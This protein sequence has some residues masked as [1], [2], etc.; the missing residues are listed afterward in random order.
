MINQIWLN[1]KSQISWSQIFGSKCFHS[2]MKNINIPSN[3]HFIDICSISYLVLLRNFREFTYTACWHLVCILLADQCW[4]LIFLCFFRLFSDFFHAFNTIF[5]DLPLTERHKWKTQ[6]KHGQLP[7]ENSN[8]QSSNMESN[9]KGS[10]LL[11][12][13]ILFSEWELN[14]WQ[15]LSVGQVPNLEDFPLQNMFLTT[16]H[17]KAGQLVCTIIKFKQ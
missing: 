13:F 8:C 12:S 14:N 15:S 17:R 16:W 4:H 3:S 2:L 7:Q 10:W 6:R 1:P 5:I 9:A 11:T